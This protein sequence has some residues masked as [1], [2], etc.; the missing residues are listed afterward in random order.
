MAAALDR[1]DRDRIGNQPRLGAGLDREQAREA[2]TQGHV[3]S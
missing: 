1:A 2:R 3:H